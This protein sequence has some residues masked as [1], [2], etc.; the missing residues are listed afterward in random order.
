MF[1]GNLEKDEEDINLVLG[2]T[3]NN[4][5]YND[6]EEEDQQQ[7]QQIKAQTARSS[8]TEEVKKCPMCDWDFPANMTLEGKN[9]HIEQ[10]FQ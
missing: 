7:Q 8:L 9:E 5:Q 10:H 3:D 4:N 2:N 6:L 1:N